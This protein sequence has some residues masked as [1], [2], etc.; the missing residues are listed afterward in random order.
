MALSVTRYHG[1]LSSCTISGKTDD[2]WLGEFSDGQTDGGTDGLTNR[3]T[4]E[5]DFIG[6]CPTNVERPTIIM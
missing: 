1:H 3:E 5:S 2:Q 6:S 4:D